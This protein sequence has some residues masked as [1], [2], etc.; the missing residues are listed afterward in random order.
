LFWWSCFFFITLMFLFFSKFYNLNIFICRI[1]FIFQEILGFLF[2]FNFFFFFQ[3]F[4]IYI[5]LGVRPLHFWVF[6]FV[7]FLENFLILWLFILYKISFLP[8]I[9][10]I[11]LD[12]FILVLGG[13][14]LIYFQMY[15]VSYY[16]FLFVYSSLESFSWLFIILEFSRVNYVFFF[17]FI[18]L[19]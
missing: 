1:F 2:L 10:L 5:K 12:S 4:F 8:V 11:L 18:I 19:L 16:K 17:S 9:M 7:F 6:F 15:K 13:L 3:L 14:L